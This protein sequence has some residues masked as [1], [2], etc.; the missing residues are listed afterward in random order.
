MRTYFR[1]QHAGYSFEDMT[2]FVSADGGD[3]LENIGGLCACSTVADLL[4]NTVMGAMS[5]NDEVVVFSAM[6]IAEIYDGYRVEP[7]AELAR[8]TVAEFKRDA[9][10]VAEQYEIW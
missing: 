8:F 7:V 6:K 2:S 3:D 9:E 1:A 10:N 5:A 4:R